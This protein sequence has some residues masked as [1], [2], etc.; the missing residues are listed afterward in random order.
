MES[1][2]GSK[3]LDAPGS[4]KSKIWGRQNKGHWFIFVNKKQ[5]ETSN[6]FLTSDS[7]AA[8]SFPALKEKLSL[9]S[10][11]SD[12]EGILDEGY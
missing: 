6:V 9:F 10:R 8:T 4:V 5:I 1:P 2:S 3:A 12:L 7:Q 11:E